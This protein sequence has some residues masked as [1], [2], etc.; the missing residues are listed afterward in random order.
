[1][2]KNLK[3]MQELYRQGMAIV[4]QMESPR[5]LFY[6]EPFQDLSRLLSEDGVSD[7]RESNRP[8]RKTRA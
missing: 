5:K 6:E 3:A 8:K 7:R 4:D 2:D 1:M